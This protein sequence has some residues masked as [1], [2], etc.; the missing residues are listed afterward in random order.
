MSRRD[1]PQTKDVIPFT[2][3]R[4][5]SADTMEAV[6]QELLLTLTTLRMVL[7]LDSGL[8][9]VMRG[10]LLERADAITKLLE[11]SADSREGT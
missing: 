10:S 8:N 1:L 6:A 11:G 7:R 4:K 9:P 5:Q 2:T 3:L